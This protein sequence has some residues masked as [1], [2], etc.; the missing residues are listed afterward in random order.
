MR[1][2]GRFVHKLWQ[3]RTTEGIEVRLIGR[4]SSGASYALAVVK[5]K[6]KRDSPALKLLVDDAV[7][8]PP[9]PG[10]VSI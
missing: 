5:L 7:D 4:G 9:A 1:V 6:G 8:V 3:R 10:A 2:R